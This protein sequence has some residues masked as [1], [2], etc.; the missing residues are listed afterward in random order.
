MEKLNIKQQIYM[1]FW[2][3]G[4]I[5]KAEEYAEEAKITLEEKKEVLKAM[6]EKK[7]K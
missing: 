2:K 5:E 1:E 4:L 7:E 6:D 3:L